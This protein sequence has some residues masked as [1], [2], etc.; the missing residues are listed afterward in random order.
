MTVVLAMLE[1]LCLFNG[2]A[3]HERAE[4]VEVGLLQG[5][6]YKMEPSPSMLLYMLCVTDMFCAL[7]V[8]HVKNWCFMH[9]CCMIFTD[10]IQ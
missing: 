6:W 7:H 9:I 8:L 10:Q 1:K 2:H 3:E 4:V 5:L